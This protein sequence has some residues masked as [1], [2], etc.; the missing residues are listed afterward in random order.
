MEYNA[1]AL[2]QHWSTTLQLCQLEYNASA[3]S[4]GVQRFSFVSTL[5]YNALALYQHWSTTL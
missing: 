5:E 3:L 2:Y 4:I 1:L